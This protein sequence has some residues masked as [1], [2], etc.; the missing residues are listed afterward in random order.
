EPL[1]DAQRG[2][3]TKLVEEQRP[4]RHELVDQGQTMLR[5]LPDERSKSRGAAKQ[6]LALFVGAGVGRVSTA[7]RK[8]F[9]TKRFPGRCDPRN[10]PAA[11]P[12][13]APEDDSS[14]RDDDHPIRAAGSLIN[15][16]TRWPGRASG[17]RSQT[18]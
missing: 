2:Q 4:L 9:G 17:I 14:P 1:L 7:R 10:E 16:K 8:S 11:R 3:L 6:G 18:L 15:R 13:S 12:N 5:L